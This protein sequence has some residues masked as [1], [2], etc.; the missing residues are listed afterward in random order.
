[1]EGPG[2]A[3]AE[4]HWQRPGV[5][6]TGDR[7][8]RQPDGRLE[9]LGRIDPLVNLSGQLVSLSEVRDVLLDHPFVA[10]AEVVMRPDARTVIACVVPTDGTE[11]G[12][13]LA[14]EL[15][16]T[17]RETLGG[18]ARPRGV[19]FLDRFGHELSPEIRR[20]ALASV[21]AATGT[22]ASAGP[23]HATVTWR[24]VLS[25]ATDQPP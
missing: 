4:H 12:G 23:H 19:L 2:A 16:E 15:A 21:A 9:F 18:L 17:V 8:V 10:A 22:G 20:R 5:Y 13:A 3:D 1:M 7:A 14:A 6:A 24:Q 11:T 25:A